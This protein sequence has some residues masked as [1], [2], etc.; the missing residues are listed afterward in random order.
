MGQGRRVVLF[1][2]PLQ[3]HI[4]PM[5]QLANILH[6]K[7]FS[8]TMIHTN[9]NSL[10][11][12]HYPQFTFHS[13]FDGVSETEASKLDTIDLIALINLRC[14]TPFKDCLAKLLSDNSE[15]PIACLISDPTFH[16]VQGV[17]D[18]LHLPKF[19]LRTSGVLSFLAFAAFPL[20]RER[21]YLPI[22][23]SHLE[24]AVPELPP[25]QVKELPVID[26]RDPDAFYQLVS[27]IVNEGKTS[28]G[29]IWNSIEEL[30]T[31]ALATLHQDFSI[32]MFPIGPFHKYFPA[33]SSS[34]SSLLAQ[35]QTCI[36]WLNRQQPK[37]VVYVSFGS[38]AAISD[39]EFL[40]IAWGL[41]YSKQPFL[42]V[43][44]PGLIHGSEWLEPLPKGFLDNVGGKG[45]IVKWAPQ[46]EV[47]AHPAV[48]AFWTHNG[49][50]STL[51]SICEGIPMICMPFFTDQKVNAKYVT[52]V[53]RVGLKVGNMG[54]ERGDVE[55]TIRKIMVE[56]EGME[57]RERMLN[58]KEKVNV[59][60]KQGGSSHQ[61]LERLVSY[62]LHLH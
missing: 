10:N 61:A 2:Y 49:W 21:G 55:R 17:T 43:I 32:P 19:V 39:T 48:G 50:N 9:Y 35:D 31:L 52:H 38:I 11:S 15:E 29:I 8:I 28:S 53:W 45:H 60:L 1:P 16:F 3:G 58:L 23:D 12:S 51:E 33:A 24:E 62:I 57:I 42:W 26:A 27:G 54:L 5:L 36:S 44:R 25:L 13:I 47:L 40:E 46:L 14:E 56:N 20:L 34:S 41:A 30:E 37:S 7:G 18:T 6:T 59:C 4:N 22:Q